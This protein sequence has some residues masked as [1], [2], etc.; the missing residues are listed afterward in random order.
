MRRARISTRAVLQVFL[1]LLTLA[2]GISAFIFSIVFRMHINN[3]LQANTGEDLETSALPCIRTTLDVC[4]NSVEDMCW[5]KC[6]PWGYMCK[7][8]P[9]V[10]LYCNDATPD[11]SSVSGAD[12]ADGTVDGQ[13]RFTWC[14]YL[15]DITGECRTPICQRQLMIINMTKIAVILCVIAV[16]LDVVDLF[17][18]C[19]APDSIACKATVNLLASACKWLAFGVLIGTGAQ[20]F[21]LELHKNKCYNIAGQEVV[22]QTILYFM[23]FSISVTTSAVCSLAES[24]FSAYYGGKLVGVPYVK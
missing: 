1:T 7:I 20:E 11:C 22:E 15:A 13:K 17:T 2:T 23:I 16:I 18:F 3:K 6:C 4:N 5:D 24:P 14:L 10:G 21:L 9:I 12:A 19:I 8:S